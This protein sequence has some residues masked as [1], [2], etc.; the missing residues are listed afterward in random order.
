[1][2]GS[3]STINISSL[4]PHL[5]YLRR[6]TASRF[7]LI[8]LLIVIAI[9]AILAA[10]LLPA[11][12]NAREA[13]RAA[14]CIGNLKQVSLG[15]MNY[16]DAYQRFPKASSWFKNASGRTDK[17]GGLLHEQSK[18]SPKN[19]LCPSFPRE[20][21]AAETATGKQYIKELYTRRKLEVDGEHWPKTDYGY[22]FNYMDHSKLSQFKQPS[23]TIA[24]AETRNGVYNSG[25][26]TVH[27]F[28]WVFTANY[29]YV[30]PNHNTKANA[31]YVA[32]HVAPISGIGSSKN[33]TSW[34]RSVYAEKG[35]AAATD[36]TPNRWGW[37]P[38]VK[39][40]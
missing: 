36:Y 18:L 28:I 1:M 32:G 21:R 13:A 37:D 22:N 39:Y 2:H 19:F 8:E 4:T 35:P 33:R 34:I 38:N 26:H 27:S 29:F 24:A 15:L 11:L 31:L 12:N 25:Q 5:S 17:W 9:I 7:T 3:K 16:Y 20:K 23:Y 6:K 14:S 40:R 10:M 30:Y